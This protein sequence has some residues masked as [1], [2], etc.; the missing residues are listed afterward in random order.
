MRVY[1][2]DRVRSDSGAFSRGFRIVYND[3]SFPPYEVPC[4]YGFQ[5]VMFDSFKGY[6]HETTR[7]MTKTTIKL[8][9]DPAFNGPLPGGTHRLGWYGSTSV[10]PALPEWSGFTFGSLVNALPVVSDSDWD[11][12]GEEAFIA[13]STQIESDLSIANSLFE[14]RELGSLLPKLAETLP[15]TLASITLWYNFGL[16]PTLADVSALSNVTTK[17]LGA[18][19]KLRSQNGKLHKVFHARPL[20]I[21]DYSIYPG[22]IN[23]LLAGNPW[24]RWSMGITSIRKKWKSGGYVYQFLQDLDSTY[25]TV[26]AFM[27]AMGLNNPAAILWEALPFSFVVDWFARIGRKISKFGVDWLQP[28]KGT[29]YIS[30]PWTSL[31]ESFVLP[32][33]YTSDWWDGSLSN[34]QKTPLRW[35]IERYTRVPEFPMSEMPSIHSLNPSQLLLANALLTQSAPRSL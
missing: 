20:V 7:F 34:F 10:F 9:L 5:T 27:A 11:D 4:P 18:I 29:W 3:G 24:H 28:Y 22:G 14:L 35:L 23:T 21:E 13:N 33:R 30:R 6:S 15:K 25:S 16:K 31:T 17:V 32:I 2:W 8:G 1:H 26:R 12:F 19:E